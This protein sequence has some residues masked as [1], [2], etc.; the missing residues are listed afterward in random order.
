[1]TDEPLF[2][3]QSWQRVFEPL[4]P[5]V[6]HKQRGYRH[7][8]C[9]G[10]IWFDAVMYRTVSPNKSREIV[11]R[12]PGNCSCCGVPVDGPALAQVIQREMDQRGL[13]MYITDVTISPDVSEQPPPPL[14]EG[15]RTHE[16]T[17]DEWKDD[18][19]I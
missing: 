8:L 12:V 15:W 7:E 6:L 17:G 9:G 11:V 14:P 3:G 18:T 5:H 10:W 2:K 1:M 19:W 4:G 16:S 13:S